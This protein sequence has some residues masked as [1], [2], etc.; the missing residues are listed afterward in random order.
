METDKCR[1]T[2][3]SILGPLL[4]LIFINDIVSDIKATIKLFA[5]DTSIYLTVDTPENTA[6][7][8]NGDLNKIHMW[9]S[10]LVSCKL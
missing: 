4:F 3:G 8:L 10:K 7:I 1:D 6:E 5:D 2:Q 9:S